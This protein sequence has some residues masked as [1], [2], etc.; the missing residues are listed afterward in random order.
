M[1]FEVSMGIFAWFAICVFVLTVYIKETEPRLVSNTRQ[2]CLLGLI[3]AGTIG[4]NW[5]ILTLGWPGAGYILPVA[6]GPMLV[7]I[8]FNRS[9]AILAAIFVGTTVGL[10]CYNSDGVWHYPLVASA[11][12]LISVFSV[13]RIRQRS[14]FTK[15][16][17]I[18]GSGNAIAILSLSLI[19]GEP[20]RDTGINALIGLT[21]GIISAMIAAFVLSFLEDIFKITTDIKLLELSDL[22]RPLLKNLVIKAPGTY[23]HSLVVGNLA[24]SCARAIGAN[25]LLTRVGCYYHD[26]GKILMPAY[27]IENQ[28][29]ENKHENLT[30]QMSSLILISHVKDGLALAEEN[31]LPPAIVDFIEQHHGTCLISQFYQLALETDLSA[32]DERYRYPGPKPQTRETALAMLADSVE[33]ASRAMSGRSHSQ[34]EEVVRSIINDRFTEGQFDECDLILKDLYQIRQSL[35]RDL[36]SILHSRSIKARTSYKKHGSTDKK[37]PKTGKNPK[38]PDKKSSR[39]GSAK[40]AGI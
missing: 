2:M 20:S 14:D 4:I 11:G 9:L 39:V 34:I 8:L 37:Q 36:T 7:A 12:G 17:I 16:G 26:I 40:V 25:A 5:L 15:A 13:V 18:V 35:T 38:E 3:L 24:E 31:K 28:T 32:S 10:I 33:A 1:S 27:F 21:G 6:F 29:G 30:P 22:N 19:T 23:H